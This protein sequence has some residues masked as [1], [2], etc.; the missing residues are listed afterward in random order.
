[1]A[2]GQQP[3]E[4]ALSAWRV[5]G[6]T[7]RF[8]PSRY[9]GTLSGHVHAPRE[10]REP[11]VHHR[12]PVGVAADDGLNLAFSDI[13]PPSLCL[14]VLSGAAAVIHRSRLAGSDGSRGK[15]KTRQR[16]QGRVRWRLLDCPLIR[17]VRPF[18]G[19]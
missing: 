16:G 13:G 10:L 1:M 18:V 8:S 17:F 6:S 15:K 12:S 4:G 19:C 3:W 14:C 11:K 7:V 9:R 5:A 2:G